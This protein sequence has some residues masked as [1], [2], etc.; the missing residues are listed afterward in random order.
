MA[1]NVSSTALIEKYGLKFNSNFSC[2]HN[3]LINAIRI[4]RQ[5]PD[6]TFFPE[7]YAENI[8]AYLLWQGQVLN[9]NVTAKPNVF[10]DF[11]IKEIKTKGEN[12]TL[13]VLDETLVAFFDFNSEVVPYQKEKDECLFRLAIEQTFEPNKLT[14]V[15]KCLIRWRKQLG[16]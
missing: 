5:E 4:A 15:I 14:E 11:T 7:I 13:K 2:F 1:E 3:A 10:D 16:W 9:G 8:H 6:T 12:Y